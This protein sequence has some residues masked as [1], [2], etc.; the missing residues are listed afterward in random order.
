LALYRSYPPT[1][2]S[3]EINELSILR[4]PAVLALVGNPDRS[5]LWRWIQKHQFPP[6]VKLSKRSIGWRACDVYEW[7]ASRRSWCESAPAPRRQA[8]SPDNTDE[9]VAMIVARRKRASAG[10]LR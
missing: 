3:P 5:T 1:V 8:I 2:L 9:A 7:L 6:S 4:L 10:A